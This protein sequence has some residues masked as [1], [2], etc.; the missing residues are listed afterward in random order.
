VRLEVPLEIHA[1][2]GG[3]LHEPGIDAP[4]RT[5]VAQRD[6]GDEVLLEPCNRLAGGKLVDP[7]GVDPRVDRARHQRHAAWLRRVAR[8]RHHGNGDER[9][10]A[11]LAHGDD[12]RTRPDRLDKRD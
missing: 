4:Q 12:V 2:E 10:D 6:A 7:R 8:L 11:R 5:A 3:K 9:G 1:H